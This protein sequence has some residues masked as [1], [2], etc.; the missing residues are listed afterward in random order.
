MANE[1]LF[2]VDAETDGLYGK[3]L[4][5]AALST[6]EDGNFD[7]YFYG[8]VSDPTVTSDWVKENVVPHLKNAERFYTTEAGK[9]LK[10]SLKHGLQGWKVHRKICTK[11]L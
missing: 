5:V 2:I 1:K 6:D 9:V 10:G 4:S 11:K 8:A 7:D 3:F